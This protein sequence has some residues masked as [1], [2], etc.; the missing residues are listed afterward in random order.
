M[1]V[2]SAEVL[3]IVVSD[4]GISAVYIVYN[5]GPRM[6]P[7][8]TSESIGNG[9]EVSLFY[10]VTKYLC[11]RYDFRR[12]NYTGER[13]CLIFSRR[14]QCHTLSNAWLMSKKRLSNIVTCPML[15]LLYL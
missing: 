11:C 4:C 8:G 6:F 10:V 5:N 15:C 3:R 9:S 12:L 2:S 7:W 1:G 13:V 14:P